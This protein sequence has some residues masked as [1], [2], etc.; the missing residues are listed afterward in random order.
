MAR[1]K[2]VLKKKN[3]S[4]RKGGGLTINKSNPINS[5]SKKN[6]LMIQTGKQ[7]LDIPNKNVELMITNKNRITHMQPR[8]PP[9]KI[10]N[11]TSTRPNGTP[12]PK[13]I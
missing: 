2:R 12:K 1:T 7:I 8:T 9:L 10:T 3:K 4:R 13:T 11:G 6:P 5:P